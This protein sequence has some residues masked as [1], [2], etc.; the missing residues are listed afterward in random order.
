[1]NF[2][3]EIKYYFM[4]FMEILLD[5]FL[6]KRTLKEYLLIAICLSGLFSFFVILSVILNV[7]LVFF[8][9]FLSFLLF[10]PLL[11]LYYLKE[12]M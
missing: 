12:K 5:L 11:F 3:K 10:F 1:M 8:F 9:L 4:G 6:G 2:K 7:I